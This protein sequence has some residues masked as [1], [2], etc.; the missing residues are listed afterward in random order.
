MQWESLGEIMEFEK[1][2]ETIIDFVQKPN[3]M[4]CDECSFV[5]EEKREKSKRTQRGKDQRK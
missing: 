4:D 5:V 1:S 3:A 2:E